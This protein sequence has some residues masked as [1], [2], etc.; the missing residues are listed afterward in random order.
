MR[1]D[2]TGYDVF[3]AALR[4]LLV[5][6]QIEK[7]TRKWWRYDFC[8]CNGHVI[9]SR[10]IRKL[11]IESGRL[12]IGRYLWY[13]K[14]NISSIDQRRLL[15][16]PCPY[17]T[18]RVLIVQSWY[19]RLL[20]FRPWFRLRSW[21]LPIRFIFFK[22]HQWSRNV[23]AV[24]YSFFFCL[25]YVFLRIHFFQNYNMWVFTSTLL[26]LWWRDQT[27]EI[28]RCFSMHTLMVLMFE[29]HGQRKRE[30]FKNGKP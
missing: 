5:I 25:Q 10:Y 17:S 19:A 7:W 24:L 27:I 30:V 6:C 13:W 1:F 4:G 12:L 22:I 21:L 28:S 18:S 9:K 16:V 2:A 8:L 11:L 26:P 20:N 15:R 29:H 3:W 14:T 23:L